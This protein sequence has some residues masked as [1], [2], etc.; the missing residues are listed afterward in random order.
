MDKN[1][2]Y[3]G[4]CRFPGIVIL[5]GYLAENGDYLLTQGKAN[6]KCDEYGNGQG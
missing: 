6:G 4:L 5:L 1:I 2:F 3:Y